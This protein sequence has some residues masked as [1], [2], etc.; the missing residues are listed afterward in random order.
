MRG[1]T[2]STS[3][4]SIRGITMRRPISGWP[5]VREKPL[6]SRGVTWIVCC[7]LLRMIVSVTSPSFLRL[8]DRDISPGES[9]ASPSNGCDHVAGFQTRFR[10]WSIVSD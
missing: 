7:D 6:P 10:C 2:I 1:M 4:I 5:T 8:I 3:G 9:I